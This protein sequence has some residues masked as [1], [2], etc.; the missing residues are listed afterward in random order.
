[1]STKRPVAVWCVCVQ[2]IILYGEMFCN[3]GHNAM[4]VALLLPYA[5]GLH[6][7]Y[8]SKSSENSSDTDIR[9]MQFLFVIY[10]YQHLVALISIA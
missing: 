5:T 4:N 6:I 9:S 2:T 10:I 1:M 3:S 8:V 7:L